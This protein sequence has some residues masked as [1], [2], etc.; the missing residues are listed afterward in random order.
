M[1]DGPATGDIRRF[2]WRDAANALG[3]WAAQAVDVRCDASGRVWTGRRRDGTPTRIELPLLVLPD[4]PPPR[5]DAAAFAARLR[6][7]P[8]RTLVLLLRAGAMAA[9]LWDDDDLLAHR[10]RRR[11]VVRGHG[12]AQTTH[13]RRRGKSRYGSRLRLQNA[14]RLVDDIAGCV[15]EWAATWGEPERCLLSCPVRQWAAITAAHPDLALG[16]RPPTRI[17][18]HVREPRFDELRRIRFLL[19]HGEVRVGAQDA[20]DRGSGW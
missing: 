15:A 14:R 2:P 12:R 6:A 20:C 10:V 9:G 7:R 16:P 17:P 1:R 3:E 19:A 8:G 13:L 5:A 18:F 4:E 11:Y